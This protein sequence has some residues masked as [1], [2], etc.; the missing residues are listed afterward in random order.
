ME[1]LL[2]IISL[3]V[4]YMVWQ[5]MA[6]KGSLDELQTLV[7]KVWIREGLRILREEAEAAK[8][9]KPR[10][11]GWKVQRKPLKCPECRRTIMGPAALAVHLKK[12]RKSV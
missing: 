8:G 1:A 11:R 10:K 5:L 3:G 7:A 12:C 6:I 2:I 4:A 9:K